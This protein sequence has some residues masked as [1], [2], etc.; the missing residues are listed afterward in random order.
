MKILLVG[1]P[2]VGKT[3]LFNALTGEN[4]RT[5]NYHG[6]T[7]GAAERPMKGKKDCLVCDLPGLYSLDGMSME[8]KLAADYIS[9]QEALFKEGREKILIL[10]VVDLRY[11][12]RS[13]KLTRSLLTRGIPV[14][15]ACTMCDKFRRRKGKFDVGAF[16][17][18]T[19]MN[20]IL[21]KGFSPLAVK[22]TKEEI[23]SLF[24]LVGNRGKKADLSFSDLSACYRPSEKK[25]GKFA[26]IFLN[27]FVAFPAF[28]LSAAALFWV[29]FGAGMP[30][31][32][33]KELCERGMGALSA[34]IGAKLSSP[35]VRSLVCGGFFGGVG[36]VLS[37]LPQIAIVYLFLDLLEESGFLSWLAFATDGFFSKFGLSGRAFFS[38]LLGFS[39]TA[40]A[41]S[42]TRSLDNKREQKRAVACLYFLPCSA[43]LPVFL[44][45][46]SSVFGNAFLGAVLLYLL[47]LGMGL[48][49]SAFADKGE[50]SFLMELADICVPNPF[51]TLKK[52]LFQLKQFIIKVSTAV[53][54]FTLVVWFLSSFGASGVCAPEESFLAHIC[55]VLKY[56][57]YPMGVTDWRLAF[58]AVGGFIAKENIAGTIALLFPE[59]LDLGFRSAC[60]F[61]TFVA[62]IPPCVSAVTAC[63]GELGAKTAWGYAAA[64]TLFAFFCSYEVY[65]FLSGGAPIALALLL[66]AAGIIA[67]RRAVL[68]GRRERVYRRKGTNAERIHR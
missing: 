12:E 3:T 32:L 9:R 25:D 20:A 53:L 60:A 23:L 33:L 31:V 44:T 48:A 7:V 15:L 8:E 5:G 45:L 57:F 43:K 26:D 37:F 64:Q 47:G 1:N 58:A 42:S 63:S 59:G 22:R 49:V 30:G 38:V 39:C 19:G 27:P 35:L 51:F 24:S 16:S 66:L 11:L 65:F 2:N 36:S 4:F 55:G 52:L 41:I 28:F 17:K 10:Q 61:L 29:A 56:A 18:I 34:R 46:L 21:I 62:L 54:A 68:R 67:A 40:A 50:G 6:V 13:L 14:A